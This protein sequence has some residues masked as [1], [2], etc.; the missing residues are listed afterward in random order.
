LVFVTNTPGQAGLAWAGGAIDVDPCDGPG[1]SV[2]AAEFRDRVLEYDGLARWVVALHGAPIA[3][4][5]EITDEFDGAAFGSMVL[6]FAGGVSLESR[7]QPPESSVTTLR[8]ASSFE[9]P[10]RVRAAVRAR[11]EEI[12]LRIDWSAPAEV[13]TDGGER[14]ERHWDPEQGLNASAAF[15]FR[16]DRLVAVSIGMAP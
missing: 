11:A 2:W 7:T 8:A 12:G 1:A 10:E 13:T 4:D 14:V 16:D 6:T 15:V 5:G 3:C 9:D